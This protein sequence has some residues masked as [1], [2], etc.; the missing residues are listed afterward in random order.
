[1]VLTSLLS[2]DRVLRL[3]T[4]LVEYLYKSVTDC[5]ILVE[6]VY[7]KTIFFLVDKHFFRDLKKTCLYTNSFWLS[8]VSPGTRLLCHKFWSILGGNI[9]S[10]TLHYYSVECKLDCEREVNSFTMAL[11]RGHKLMLHAVRQS[12]IRCFR[13]SSVVLSG[14]TQSEFTGTN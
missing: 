5:R 1:M 10:K 9:E 6:L 2:W 14:G 4:S 11:L 3:S 8:L 7:S 13:S 12:S